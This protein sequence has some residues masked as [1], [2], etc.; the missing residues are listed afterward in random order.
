MTENNI[1]FFLSNQFTFEKTSLQSTMEEANEEELINTIKNGSNTIN[2]YMKAK[3]W[4][5]YFILCDKYNITKF[6]LTKE[7]IYQG[8]LNTILRAFKTND[9]VINNNT[10]VE[11]RK[12]RFHGKLILTNAQIQSYVGTASESSNSKIS[13]SFSAVTQKSEE[14]K[15][16][17]FIIY[18]IIENISKYLLFL[19]NDPSMSSILSD[20]LPYTCGLAKAS[21]VKHKEKAKR[22]IKYKNPIFSPVINIDKKRGVGKNGKPYDF[23]TQVL[24]GRDTYREG[25]KLMHR[26]ISYYN[27]STNETDLTV[28]V[29]AF[30]AGSE[31]AMQIEW[32]NVSS[33]KFIVC[34]PEINFVMV[35]TNESYTK[36]GDPFAEDAP[37]S[38]TPGLIKSGFN[39]RV[40]EDDDKSELSFGSEDTNILLSS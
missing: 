4:H 36:L 33:N 3:W 14:C 22:G 12:I 29:N 28:L 27:P 39:S 10:I 21:S 26:S 8:K 17:F 25:T 35:T 6:S 38:D 11:S 30:T 32:N 24:N 1:E 34:K 40:V 2:G 9:L 31:C 5:A 7:G 16:N 23:N 13:T 20:I 15:Y 18:N 37:E 19:S